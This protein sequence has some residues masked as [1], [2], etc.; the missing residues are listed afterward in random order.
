[1]RLYLLILTLLLVSCSYYGSDERL[2]P[3]FEL[4][5]RNPRR[6]L[7]LLD[8]ID[9]NKL[10]SI[11]I[12]YYHFI[13]TKATDQAGMP[14]TSAKNILKSA[15]YF[16]YHNKE[17]YPEALFYVGR[18]FH[19]IGD[20]PSAIEYIEKA[21]L[22][23]PALNITLKRDTYRELGKLY[24]DLMRYSDAQSYIR[25]ALRADSL[26]CD[27]VGL[28]QDGRLLASYIICSSD[29]AAIAEN[30]G[31]KGLIESSYFKYGLERR[32]NQDI[33][34]TKD[35]YEYW[36]VAL[37]FLCYSLS[38]LIFFLWLRNRKQNYE[39]RD[40]ISNF[41]LLKQSFKSLQDEKAL[42]MEVHKPKVN[43]R[44]ELRQELLE[45]YTNS[46]NQPIDQRIFESGVYTKLQGLINSNYLIKENSSL[47]DELE[48]I[49]LAISP[50]FKIHLQI[51]TGGKLT[52]QELHTAYLI[53]CG[54]T[55]TQMASLLGRT[56]GSISSRRELLC[57]K[58]FDKKLGAKVIDGI[59]RCL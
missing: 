11:D 48:E 43:L 31:T 23:V 20:Y 17:L 30:S 39:L 37:F 22:E 8:S 6:A 5:D 19:S 38:A 14:H 44:E 40:A 15:H 41:Q 1:M 9:C 16:K 59:I 36:L 25:L 21:L 42:L 13:C 2:R 26:D 24:G 49:V 53:K 7:E 47:W 50:N 55:P 18:V 28:L 51:L 33:I 3:A 29:S 4:V 54:I 45:I 32:D 27:S 34:A 52:Q 56:K 12:P 58:V 35:R 10:T 46:G 57:L